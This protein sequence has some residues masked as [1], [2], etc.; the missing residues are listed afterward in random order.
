MPFFKGSPD[1]LVMK[2]K[3][4][5]L[6][7]ASANAKYVYVWTIDGNKF[8]DREVINFGLKPNFN[9]KV[10]LNITHPDGSYSDQCQ[11]VDFSSI[12]S[13]QGLKVTILPVQV[14]NKIWNLQAKIEGGQKPIKYAWEN[15]ST[16]PGTSSN[17]VVELDIKSA[18]N[19]CLTIYDHRGNTASACI[20][21]QPEGKV[22]SRADFDINVVDQNMLKDFIQFNTVEL[23]YTDDA[24]IVWSTAN[25]NQKSIQHSKLS[26]SLLIRIMK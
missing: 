7:A 21:L 23:I 26:K 11:T 3:N 12:D 8:S 24:G 9:S 18:S 25:K 16:I 19:H 10:C 5:S 1:S 22:K 13:F 6:L 4:N 14:S 15:K 20:D 2:S 17:E